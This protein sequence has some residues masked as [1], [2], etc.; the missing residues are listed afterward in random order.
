MCERFSAGFSKLLFC[1]QV[2]FSSRFQKIILFSSFHHFQ[3][4]FILVQ[5]EFFGKAAKK[6]IPHADGKNLKEKASVSDFQRKKIGISVENFRLGCQNWPLRNGG[7]FWRKILMR[8]KPFFIVSELPAKNSDFERVNSGGIVRTATYLIEK[9]FQRSV[10]V[11]TKTQIT[12]LFSDFQQNCFGPLANLFGRVV[13]T[14]SWMSRKTFLGK[15]FF[16]KKRFSS[17]LSYVENTLGRV[18]KTASRSPDKK[19]SRFALKKKIS[20]GLGN[21][22]AFYLP[23]GT[24]RRKNF[25]RKK[26]FFSIKFGLSAKPLGVLAEK[27]QQFFQNWILRPRRNASKNNIF[28]DETNFLSFTVFQQK[29]IRL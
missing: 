21:K 20:F 26:L 28:W 4:T 23:N 3:R 18:F 1:V 16:A 17:F 5:A 10:D 22:T 29:K 15:N 25:L 24:F 12:L 11:F 9:P 2:Y 6:V 19:L 27:F 14:D 8:T 7:T 13:T